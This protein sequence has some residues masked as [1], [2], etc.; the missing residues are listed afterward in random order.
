MP[1]LPTYSSRGRLTT[2]QPE[3]TRT[4]AGDVAAAVT[5]AANTA[6]SVGVQLNAIRNQTQTSR[7]MADF[8]YGIKQIALEAQQD[9][10]PDNLHLHIDKIKGLKEDALKRV[11]DPVTR[12]RVTFE[13]MHNG[14]LAEIQLG[15]LFHQKNIEVAK[16]AT[17]RRLELL[18]QEYADPAADRKIRDAIQS[19]QTEL[20]E[21]MVGTGVL[22]VLE[23]E[24]LRKRLSDENERLREKYKKA[25]DRLRLEHNHIE[26]GKAIMAMRAGTLSPGTLKYEEE[27]GNISFKLS[28]SLYRA[29]TTEP[30]NKPE[31]LDPEVAL[32]LSK[33]LYKLDKED[34]EQM[35]QLRVDLIDAYLQGQIS[36][37]EFDLLVA[38]T[39][40]PYIASPEERNSAWGLIDYFMLMTPGNVG[41]GAKITARVMKDFIAYKI[42]GL[43]NPEATRMAIRKEMLYSFP[44]AVSKPNYRIMD[45][46]G[47]IKIVTVDGDLVDEDRK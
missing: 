47:V 12:E 19:K 5:Q 31:N 24:Q 14:R 11:K 7:A 21:E 9:T 28:K 46:N 43:S 6:F 10:N 44:M 35:Q 17:L 38:K 33:T 29:V 13:M 22:S 26:D 2:E 37:D 40:D 42:K 41:A 32:K 25:G 39:I 20:L 15:G 4:G 8:E 16:V 1:R 18:Q 36:P 27:K 3:V 34:Y 45:A 30:I 23:A